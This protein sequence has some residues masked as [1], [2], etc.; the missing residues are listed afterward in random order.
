MKSV[1]YFIIVFC[2]LEITA[3]YSFGQMVPMILDTD[4]GPDYDDVGAMAMFH[5]KKNRKN[6]SSSLMLIKACFYGYVLGRFRIPISSHMQ[7]SLE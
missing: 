2:F 1:Y 3:Q 6:G 4:I 7:K 5:A